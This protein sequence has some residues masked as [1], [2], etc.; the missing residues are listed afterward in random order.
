[1]ILV[2]VLTTVI[3]T[4]LMTVFSYMYSDLRQKQFREPELLNELLARVRWINPQ[5]GRNHWAGWCIHYLIGLMFIAI[6]YGSG[7][8][9]SFDAYL[10]AGTLS[11]IIGI[12]CWIT[13]FALHPSPPAIRYKE[14]YLQLLIA[15]IIFGIGAYLSDSL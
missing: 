13:T 6:Y 2:I 7:I 14:Y 10:V 12:V 1:M 5:A 8:V 3:A 4:S 9:N 15:H 11:G